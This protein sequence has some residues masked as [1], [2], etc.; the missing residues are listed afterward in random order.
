MMRR[1]D[2]ELFMRVGAAS[3]EES[4]ARLIGRLVAEDLRGTA[5]APLPERMRHLLRDLQAPAD[6]GAGAAPPRRIN[7]A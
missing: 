7:G 2:E 3:G 5:E 4:M 1:E 6:G